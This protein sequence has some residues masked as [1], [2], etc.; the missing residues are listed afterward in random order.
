MNTPSLPLTNSLRHYL[1]KIKLISVPQLNWAPVCIRKDEDRYMLLRSS[2]SIGYNDI[3]GMHRLQATV[4]GFVLIGPRSPQTTNQNTDMES[5]HA[6][7]MYMFVC[8][9]HACCACNVGV[10]VVRISM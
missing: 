6:V 10:E 5:V 8:T 9:V 4:S 7:S 3:I 2:D 1:Q